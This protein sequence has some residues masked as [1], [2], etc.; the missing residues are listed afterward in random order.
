MSYRRLHTHPL[1][2]STHIHRRHREPRLR[3]VEGGS[4]PY[5]AKS[6]VIR[7]HYWGLWVD[8]ELTLCSMYL[9]FAEFSTNP[10][11][12]RIYGCLRWGGAVFTGFTVGYRNYEIYVN[13]APGWVKA[14]RTIF[15]GGD[16][17]IYFTIVVAGK[18]VRSY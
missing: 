5:A 13:H 16:R 6:E 4:K 11:A 8:A 14:E 18:C 2:L 9:F 1:Q 3:R 12:C 7:G 17:N 15:P 10:L